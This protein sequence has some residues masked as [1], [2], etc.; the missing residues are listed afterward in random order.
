[1]ALPPKYAGQKLFAAAATVQ[2]A[3]HTLELYL[4][5]VCP[6]SAKLFNTFYTSVRP[7]VVE[8]YKS[9]LQVIFRQQIQ[10]WHPS[11]TLTHE[12]A[13]AVLKVAPE[14]FWDFSAALFKHQ[15][16]FFDENVVN[17]TRNKTYGRLAKIAGSI[18]VDESEVL[19]LLVISDKPGPGGIL[20]TGNGVTNDIKFMTKV[21]RVVGVHVTPT[22]FFDGAEEKAISS[23]F[24]A[25]QWEEWLLENVI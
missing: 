3:H 22:V 13:A 23:S 6:F 11:S 1:M 18:G 14:K 12:A 19:S 25:A 21:N 9:K 15:K 2:Q 10:P 4:D 16:D 24:T 20:N 8:K 5:Y 17:E 7:V